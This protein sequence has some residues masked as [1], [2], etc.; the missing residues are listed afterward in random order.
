MN[1]TSD[2]QIPIKQY[3]ILVGVYKHWL[4]LILRFNTTYYA[5]TGAMLSFY[6]SHL[7]L[8]PLRFSLLL[9]ATIGIGLAIFAFYSASWMK[10]IDEELDEIRKTLNLG[11]TPKAVFVKLLLVWSGIFF[12]MV[13]VGLTVLVF[14]DLSSLAK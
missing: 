5:I 9:P 10:P 12:I 11:I 8:G 3:E 13:V 2:K 1:G 6:L 7:S 14:V 4:D